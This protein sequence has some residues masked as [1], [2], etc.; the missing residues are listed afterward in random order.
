MTQFNTK[1][2]REAKNQSKNYLFFDERLRGL[3][4]VKLAAESKIIRLSV[5]F[6]I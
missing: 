3:V 1:E 6:S 4:R 2:S 5:Y